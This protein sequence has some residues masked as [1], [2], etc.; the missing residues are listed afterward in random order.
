[1]SANGKYVA[2]RAVSLCA[3]VSATKLLGVVRGVLV[4]QAIGHF[5]CNEDQGVYHLLRKQ[6]FETGEPQVC[7]QRMLKLNGTQFWA[8][9]TGNAAQNA[10]GAPV[11]RVVLT[12]IDERKRNEQE[13]IQSDRV[14][15]DSGPR[16]VQ[17]RRA[18]GCEISLAGGRRGGGNVLAPALPCGARD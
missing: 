13:L 10:D 11:C 15:V 8:H 16:T 3:N 7:D 9:L 6:L 1:M 17:L 18:Q 12:D 2:A 5:I 4:T 14:Q